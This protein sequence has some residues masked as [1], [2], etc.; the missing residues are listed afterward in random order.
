[1]TQ[2]GAGSGPASAW[3]ACVLEDMAGETACLL[4][5]I[6]AGGLAALVLG[7]AGE[8]VMGDDLG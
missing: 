7:Q 1:V 8:E 6:Q 3:A 2:W 5:V 4:L